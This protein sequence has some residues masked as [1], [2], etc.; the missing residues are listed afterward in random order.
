MAEELRRGRAHIDFCVQIYR[1]QLAG[2]RHFIHEHLETST[3]WETDELKQLMLRPEVDATTV[4]MCAYGMESRDEQGQGLVKKATRFMSTSPEV[5][6]RVAARCSNERG[7]E[8]HRHVHL[9]QGRAKGAQAYPE[10][11][12]FGFARA[13]QHKRDWIAWA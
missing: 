2:K 1:M 13:S 9:I 8:Q 4:H 5:L 11:C 10:H 12:A 6:K 7:G 3:A